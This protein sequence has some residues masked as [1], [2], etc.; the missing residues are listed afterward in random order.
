M[1][2]VVARLTGV[3]IENRAAAEVMAQHDGPDTLHYVDPPYLP[4]VRSNH[5]M[6]RHEL[7]RNNHVELLNFL[8]GLEGMV[9]MSGYPSAL[10]D[11]ALLDWR[12]V[13]REALADGARKRTEVL[14]LNPALVARLEVERATLFHAAGRGEASA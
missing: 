12:R 9:V 6:Y 4:E 5:R 1:A 11:G 10:Y 8:K 2:L 3:T 7:T 14:W 13:E